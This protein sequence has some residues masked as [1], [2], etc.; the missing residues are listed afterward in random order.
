M[1]GSEVRCRAADLG[2]LK[3]ENES[4]IT[5]E[6]EKL[7]ECFLQCHGPRQI[8]SI[9]MMQLHKNSGALF[10]LADAHISTA[11]AASKSALL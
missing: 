3:V 9:S 11:A 10:L 1:Q 6:V 4:D 5:K 7:N 8:N 2:R